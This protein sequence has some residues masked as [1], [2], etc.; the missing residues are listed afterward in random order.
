MKS[1]YKLFGIVTLFLFAACA[2]YWWWTDYSFGKDG[3]SDVHPGPD[4]IG[5]VAL[6]LSGLLCLMCGGYF[7]FVSRR[8]DP[9]PEDR[10]EAEIAE[11]AGEIGFFSPGSYWPFGLALAAVTVG[12][13][14]V[15]FYWWLI[16]AG[17]VAILLATGGL[18]F[19]YYT[20]ARK[21]H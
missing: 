4:Y 16:A 14:L 8:I 12:I 13:G 11:G 15:Y 2:L 5:V 19:E 10:D 9:R 3:Y 1:E 6:A 20:G 18:L 21:A 7:W 17:M